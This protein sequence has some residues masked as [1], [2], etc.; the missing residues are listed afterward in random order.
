M[1][2]PRSAAFGTLLNLLTCAS[3]HARPSTTRHIREST[4]RALWAYLFI[5]PFYV[6]F[7]V[8]GLFPI[9]FSFY[10]AFTRWTPTTTQWIGLTNFSNMLQDQLVRT[11]LFNSLWLM[12]VIGSVQILAAL[13]I[14]FALNARVVRGR[15]VFRGIF[16]LPYITSPV[17]LGLVWGVMF[18]YSGLLN[19]L[20]GRLS[21]APVDWLGYV[22]DS[23]TWIKPAIALVTTWQF[24]GWNVLLFLAGLQAIPSEIIEAARIDGASTLDVLIRITLPL[25]KRVMFFVTSITIIGS[26]QLFDA[27]LM[28]LGGVAGAGSGT[29]GGADAAGMTLA[30]MVYDTAFNYGQFGYAA[31]ISLLMFAVLI[32]LTA[33]NRRLLFRGLEA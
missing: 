16:F 14:A 5:A 24:F 27:P 26:V 18:A 4:R 30:M 12:L 23:G 9:A 8:F 3:T 29:L 28:L 10:L 11:A 19:Y 13:L 6:G 2:A 33:G 31:A 17:V 22:T 25:L 15:E 21:I 32:V 20:L 1:T 7:L